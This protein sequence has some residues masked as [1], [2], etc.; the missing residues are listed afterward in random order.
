MKISI[1]LV[2]M[3]L[4]GSVKRFSFSAVLRPVSCFSEKGPRFQHNRANAQQVDDLMMGDH[5][6]EE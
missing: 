6:D 1:P 3:G 4:N 5:S 2:T